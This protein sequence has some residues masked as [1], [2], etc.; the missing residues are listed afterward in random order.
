MA[1]WL[2]LVWNLGGGRVLIPHSCSF[3]TKIMHPSSFPEFLTNPASQVPV[4]S[5]FPLKYLA[6]SRILYHILVKSDPE[7]IL[8]D[9]DN[10]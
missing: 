2:H 1:T 8:P 3:S 6:F 4:K 5:S 10:K 9:P 7:N